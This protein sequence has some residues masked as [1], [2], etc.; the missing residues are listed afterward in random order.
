L[1]GE[2]VNWEQTVSVGDSSPKPDAT[3]FSSKNNTDHIR[4]ADCQEP[5]FRETVP[6]V[7]PS[8]RKRSL[9]EDKSEDDGEISPVKRQKQTL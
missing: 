7:E 2:Y 1:Y 4:C 6:H 9:V 8:K 5:T 3:K